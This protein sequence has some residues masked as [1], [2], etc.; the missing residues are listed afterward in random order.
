M[1]KEAGWQQI[2]HDR[3]Q[4]VSNQK[5][6]K[7]AIDND[8]NNNIILISQ[9]WDD[10]RMK[11]HLALHQRLSSSLLTPRSF[12]L[13]ERSECFRTSRVFQCLPGPAA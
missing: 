9:K 13:K 12:H 3:I 2:L 10:E 1:S 7:G 4:A 11:L 6:R 5:A 8:T